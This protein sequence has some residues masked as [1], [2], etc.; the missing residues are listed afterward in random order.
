M[1]GNL[2]WYGKEFLA[3]AENE[4]ER[5]VAA[6]T[7]KVQREAKR[8]VSQHAGPTKTLRGA[9]PSK[10]G[11]PP[12]KRTGTLGRNI[13]QETLRRGNDFIGRVGHVGTSAKVGFW[14]ELGTRK[15]A[16]RPHLRPALDA[17]RKDIVAAIRAAGKRIRGR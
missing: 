15:M 3:S 6:G 5:A 11:E 7:I 12:H 8:L 14:L 13:G 10:P 4:I 1:P 17:V 9:Q 16:A 2:K